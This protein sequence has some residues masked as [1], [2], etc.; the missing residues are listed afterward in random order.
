M[1]ILPEKSAHL[2]KKEQCCSTA[3]S[4]QIYAGRH[5]ELCLSLIC[6]QLQRSGQNLFT[7]HSAVIDRVNNVNLNPFGNIALLIILPHISNLRSEHQ[8]IDSVRDV[9]QR[10]TGCSLDAYLLAGSLGSLLHFLTI[11]LVDIP[12]EHT[13]TILIMGSDPLSVSWFAVS[14]RTD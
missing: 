13:S 4:A 10:F 3:P 9:R 14:V 12:A 1:K 7:V 8:H 6:R 11:R 5:M 2:I